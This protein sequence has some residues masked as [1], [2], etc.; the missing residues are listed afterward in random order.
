MFWGWSGRF[1]V[2]APIGIPSS[3]INEKKQ[4]KIIIV[5]GDYAADIIHLINAIL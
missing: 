4:E 2:I 1:C 5:R 3:I